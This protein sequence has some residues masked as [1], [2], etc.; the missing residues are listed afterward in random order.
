MITSLKKLYPELVIGYSDHYSTKNDNVNNC[1]L[2]RT[3]I[4]EK[5]FTYNKNLKGNDHYH[6]MDASDLSYL[7]KK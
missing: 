2:K 4:I 5:H 3:V 7:K 1:F 6:A